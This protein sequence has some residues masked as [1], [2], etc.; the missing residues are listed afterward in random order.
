MR[1]FLCDS[2][3]NEVDDL[4]D[5]KGNKFELKYCLLGLSFDNFVQYFY[6][7]F[8]F[9]LVYFIVF[10]PI[11]V[12]KF[13]VCSCCIFIQSINQ[14]IYVCVLKIPLIPRMSLSS[15]KRDF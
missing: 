15:C 11:A 14:S 3:S 9:G 8:V 1:I 12:Y 7:V 5:P 2:F 4:K 10:S 6:L 13:L